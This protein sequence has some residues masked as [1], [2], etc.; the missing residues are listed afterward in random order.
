MALVI[1]SKHHIELDGVRYRLAESAEG[2]HHNVR[3]EPLRPPNAVTV[4]GESSQKFQPRPEVL[5]WTWTDWSEGEGRR[6]QKFGERGRSWQLNGIRAFEEPG[7]L[8]PGY[9]TEITQDSTG[10]ADFTTQGWPVSGRSNIYFWDNSAA[11]YHLW[12]GAKWGAATALGGVTNGA[13][14]QPV[15][16]EDFIYWLEK[17]TGKV[18]RWAGSAATVSTTVDNTWSFAHMEQT[19]DYLYVYRPESGKVYEV[20]K[21]GSATIT[22]DEW[23]NNGSNTNRFGRFLASMDGRIYVLVATSAFTSIREIT[24]TSAAGTGFGAEVARIE[25]F[26]AEGIWAHQGKLFI[27]GNYRDPNKER[28]VIYL[29]PGQSWGTLGELRQG[30]DLGYV[31]GGGQR[32]LD[33]FLVATQ[34]DDSNPNHSLFQLDSVTGGIALLAYDENGGYTASPEGPVVGNDGIFWTARTTGNRRCLRADPDR[35]Q[36]NSSAVSPE[37]D[38]DLVGKKF[39]SSV[40]L[41]CEPLPADWTVYVD[42]QKDGN[43]TWTNAITY[44]TDSGTGTEQAITTDAST[45]E[46]RRLQLRVRFEYTG[47]GVPTSAPV[48]LGVEAR[49]VVAEKVKVFQYLLDLSS[50]QSAGSQSKSGAS[51]VDDFLVSAI[52]ATSVDLKDGYTSPRSGEYDQ[53]D[54][55]FDEYNVVLD[56]PGE[57]IAA[58]TLREVI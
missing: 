9:Y 30:D 23:E 10:A 41:G 38:F 12:D 33:H 42:Y 51:K 11:N 14:C 27:A 55:F 19:D 47:A 40:V 46:F 18:W 22:I 29:T 21:A 24:P 32:M 25:G 52:K 15:A 26:Q 1:D 31:T 36:K 57:G 5:L 50:D 34:R 39:L 58:V 4:Q 7:H 20:H 43:G 3:G 44:T 48:V 13:A 28:T 35:Y 53:Y 8:I 49:A 17:S 54:V 45:I 56:R 6:T 37:H 16:D 2:Q